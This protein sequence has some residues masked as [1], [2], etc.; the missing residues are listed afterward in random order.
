MTSREKELESELRD[1]RA[2]LMNMLRDAE[3]DRR[4]LEEKTGKLSQTR[5]ATLNMLEDMADA[6]KEVE[7]AYQELK[8]TQSQLLQSE[9]MATIGTLAGGVAHEINN[10]LSAILMNTQILLKDSK[11]KSER[12][13]L[14]LIEENTR[15]CRDIVRSLLTYSRKPE[16]GEFE[17]IDLNRVIGD[18]SNLLQHQLKRDNIK[19]EKKCGNI[20]W[21]EGNANELQQ[22]F[23]NLILNARD[24]I[25]EAGKPGKIIISTFQKGR[26]IVSKVIDNG[27][28]IPKEDIKRIFDPFFTTKDVGK[29]TGLGL[30]IVYKIIEK[31]NG[32][33]DVSSTVN[34]G[35]VFTIR[36][37]IGK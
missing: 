16:L 4:Q 3:Q 29:G 37:P 24:A 6:K 14:K 18:S 22:V 11:D 19:I 17:S 5:L 8:T 23:T 34:K 7:N 28:E 15:R 27:V 20:P 36:L 30:S 33:I 26:F 21:I 9:K 10:P 13:S 32:R 2:A 35:T 31:H 1:T 25:K 12:E